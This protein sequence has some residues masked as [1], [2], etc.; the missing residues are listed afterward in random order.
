MHPRDLSN[1]VGIPRRSLEKIGGSK[2]MEIP[3]FKP[4]FEKF[5]RDYLD[6]TPAL[7]GEQLA[8]IKKEVAEWNRWVLA[9]R[10]RHG[11]RIVQRHRR[12]LRSDRR[13]RQ[14]RDEMRGF[15]D[16]WKILLRDEPDRRTN[17]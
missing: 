1:Y 7:T 17:R 2:E 9:A 8:A 5:K 16:R 15:Y 14:L 10:K 11:R 3:K 13:R 4:D 6:K 12:G